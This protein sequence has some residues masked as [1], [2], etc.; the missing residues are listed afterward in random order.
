VAEKTHVPATREGAAETAPTAPHA[1]PRIGKSKK[2]TGPENFWSN[3][4]VS[5]TLGIAF[6]L[7]LALHYSV[8]PWTVFPEHTLELKDTEGEISIST[9]LLNDEPVAPPPEKSDTP[10][11]SDPVAPGPGPKKNVRDAAVDEDKDG[12]ED[13]DASITDAQADISDAEIAMIGDASVVGANGP[14][15]PNSLLGAAGA[16]QAGPSL[17]QLVVNMEVIRQNPIGAQ[18]GP[19]LSAIPQW[20]EFIAG[21]NVDAVK[22]TD[23]VFITGPSLIRTDR[24]VIFVHYSTTDAKVDRA[25]DIVAHKYDRGG[26]FDAGV[27]GVKATMGHADR[28]Q[29]V[30]L[31]PQPH[32]LV[33]SPPDYAHTAATIL[34][35]AKISPHIRPGEAMRLTL[36][37]PWHVVPDLPKSMTELRMWIIPRADSG[38]D[39]NIEIDCTDAAAA[40]QGAED[41][42][43]I[44]RQ[45]NSLGVR[46]LTNG[47][48]NGFDVAV[49][50][51]MVRAR[52]PV[53]KEQLQTLLGLVASQ[54][55]VSLPEQTTPQR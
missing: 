30:F 17:V 1:T 15:D 27:P 6:F 21:T 24:D 35:H 37:T 45:Q 53:S 49:D 43:K 33:V 52:L 34:L 55:G 3:R 50:G 5:T 14:R 4:G 12:G 7:S 8:S 19:M 44:I 16:V 39:A 38:A 51:S 11:T 40:I 31:R 13:L 36:A 54:L 32:I 26:Y 47:L 22:D 9:D 28:A 20:D 23:W 48:L 18:M 25:I 29:R 42:K 2:H 46:M 41:V 10:P